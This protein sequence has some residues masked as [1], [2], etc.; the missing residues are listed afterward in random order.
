MTEGD[1]E[2]QAVLQEVFGACLDRSAPGKWFAMLVGGGDNG[3]SV[4]LHV[5]GLLLGKRNC[6][7]VGLSELTT[8]RFAAFQLF[9]KLANVVGD[10]GY[11]ESADEGRLKTLTGGDLTTFEQ[12]GRDPFS[13]VNRAKLVFACNTP[14]AFSDRS[15]AVWQRLIAVPF[16]YTVPSD[17]KDPALLT[18]GYWS[19][20]LPGI[21]NWAI[22]G[23]DRFRGGRGRFTPSEACDALKREHRQDSNPARRFLLE[24]YEVTNREGDRVQ[25][26]Q[27][28]EAY[29]LWATAEG[30]K[31]LLTGH[32]FAKEVDAAF[33]GISK[34]KTCRDG[35]GSKRCRVG[36]KMRTE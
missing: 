4:V 13:A 31:N 5:L 1:A 32:K 3:K 20:D 23:L 16:T 33:P 27:M 8:N 28:Y 2:R 7:S 24:T 35:L 15:E 12:K 22:D 11:L 17:R 36:L 6:A 14:P 29:R 34:A 10:Q 19:E 9:G 25:V 26:A 30:Y 21:L 18:E